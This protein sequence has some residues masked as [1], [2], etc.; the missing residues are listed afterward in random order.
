MVTRYFV[1]SS[2]GEIAEIIGRISQ[3]QE[4]GI[5]A[6][7]D[8]VADDV[9]RHLL[10]SHD[11]LVDAQ[12][13]LI[14]GVPQPVDADRIG[15][16]MACRATQERK[17]AGRRTLEDARLDGAELKGTDLGGLSSIAFLDVS[18]P[19]ETKVTA[20]TRFA[21]AAAANASMS[22]IA[23]MTPATRTNLVPSTVVPIWY[24]SRDLAS[25]AAKARHEERQNTRHAIM[26]N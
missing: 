7:F 11:G 17:G 24:A 9:G 19:G 23:S 15:I 4:R 22:S 2:A 10:D 21:T 8:H 16:C 6:H 26:L 20:V 25:V 3:L 1:I 12:H 14:V 18:P 13:T 5:G